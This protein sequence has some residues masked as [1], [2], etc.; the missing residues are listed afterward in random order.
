M[1]QQTGDTAVKASGLHD[2]FRK[3]TTLL[4]LYMAQ[5]PL[6]LLQQL[7]SSLHTTAANVSGMLA[8]TDI[9][10]AQLKLWRSDEEY[11][12]VFNNAQSKV[13]LLDI[14]PIKMPRTSK[15]PARLAGNAPAHHAI[16]ARDHFRS[17]YF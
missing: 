2:V 15:P 1:S 8:A 17:Q 11:S 12:V 5:K 13:D 16:S 7:N 14:D 10:I 9:A 6:A 4:G 3:G